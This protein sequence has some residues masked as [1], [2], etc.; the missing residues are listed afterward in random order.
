MVHAWLCVRSRVWV[1]ILVR[2]AIVLY[3]PTCGEIS[4]EGDMACRI[5]HTLD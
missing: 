1:T 5:L 4:T 2:D 3:L